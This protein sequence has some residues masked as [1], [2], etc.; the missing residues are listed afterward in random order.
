[1]KQWYQQLFDHYADS[2]ENEEFTK[3]TIGE[4]DFIEEAIRRNKSAKILDVGCGTGRHAIELAIRG[5]DVIGVDLSEPML[6][7]ARERAIE[8]GVSVEFLQQDARSLHF[9]NQFDLVMMVCEGGFP[10]METDEMNYQ[11]LRNAAAALKSDGKLIL[12]TL[13]GLF[14]LFHSV[15]DFVNEGT[16]GVSRAN[17]FDLL[18]FRDHSQYEFVDDEGES[19]TLQCN[20][21]YYV[22]SEITWLLRSLA[23]RTINIYGCE[24]GKWSRDVPLTT[25]HF[26]MLVVAER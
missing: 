12:T 21:R 9:T 4:A 10:L 7:K 24:I 23:F 20:E 13:N 6:R 22:P 2:Y 25:D 15:K 17:T 1:M 18:T 11:I 5:Y 19:R 16:T 8:R 3:G 26:E 14:P